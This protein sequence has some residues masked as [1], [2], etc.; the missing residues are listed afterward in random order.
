MKKI[1]YILSI[2]F[3]LIGSANSKNLENALAFMLGGDGGWQNV[4]TYHEIK[5]CTLLYGQSYMGMKLNVK[6]DFN[7]AIW[8]SVKVIEHNGQIYFRV[9]GKNG[10]QNVVAF[11]ENG[12]DVTD[13]LFFFGIAGGDSTQ[14]QF[15]ILADIERFKVALKD[16]KKKCKGI[17][18]NY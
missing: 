14:I 5:K 1:F 13:V 12:N 16:V 4:A 7:K 8:N 3:L 9:D 11:D 15:P 2:L 18:S 17:K 6:Y 10:L